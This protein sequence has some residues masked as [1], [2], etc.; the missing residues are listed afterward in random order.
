MPRADLELLEAWR[1]GD[2]TAGS[3][4]FDRHY[5]AL[6]RFFRNKAR[7]E[8]DADELLQRTL[9]ACVESVERFRGDASFRTWLFAVARNVLLESIRAKAR[10]PVDLG[11][12]SLVD[13]GTGP[14]EALARERE[15]RLLLE[16]LRRIPLESQVMLELYFWE[17]MQASEL[18][19]IFDM[20]VGT[21]RSRIRKAKD[22]LR[23]AVDAL[24][25]EP[26]RLETTQEQLEGWARRVREAWGV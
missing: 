17:G 4:L 16:A 8:T 24:A 1:A 19:Q 22:E 14:S 21:V 12:Q 6:R 7:D 9:V 13:L 23:T 11:S 20:P 2:R 3:E 26:G 15:Q 25:R 10:A 5:R 18:A